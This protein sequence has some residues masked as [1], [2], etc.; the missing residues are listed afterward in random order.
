MNMKKKNPA[1]A[2][3]G[4]TVRVENIVAL[5][6]HSD[7][8]TDTST[9]NETPAV[10]VLARRWGLPITTARVICELAGIGGVK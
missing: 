5:P 6:S 8:Q 10:R 9:K 2:L 3:A 4:A 7:L 1:A